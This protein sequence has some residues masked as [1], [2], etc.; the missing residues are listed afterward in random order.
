[1]YRPLMSPRFRSG[2]RNVTTGKWNIILLPVLLLVKPSELRRNNTLC[3]FVSLYWIVCT[4]YVVRTRTNM[5][6]IIIYLQCRY[7]FSVI[8]RLTYS[9]LICNVYEV[10]E[11]F[12]KAIFVLTSNTK[13]ARTHARRHTYTQKRLYRGYEPM[14]STACEMLMMSSN[15]VM[16][17]KYGK[18]GEK[19]AHN[20]L[21]FGFL[22]FICISTLEDYENQF[23]PSFFSLFCSLVTPCYV[24]QS[25]AETVSM[26]DC[27][28]VRTS[29]HH[30]KILVV[31][32]HSSHLIDKI[33]RKMYEF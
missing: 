30:P 18:T 6:Y 15:R 33:W 5:N 21:A 27:S 10:R 4:K 23:Y 26:F 24:S 17:I 28:I 12:R 20:F 16:E 22:Y 29:I 3:T 8:S 19:L 14:H 9:I 13:Y 31:S 25:R 2:I 11:L 7:S 32:K 1:M